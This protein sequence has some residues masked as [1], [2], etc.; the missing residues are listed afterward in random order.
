MQLI[1]SGKL[2][3]PVFNEAAAKL[4]A[5]ST[6]DDMDAG[7]AEQLILA[8]QVLAAEVLRAANSV[9]FGGLSEVNTVR[10]AIVRLGLRQVSELAML[11]S[12]RAEYDA[13]DRS[14]RELIQQLWLH[15]SATA[16]AASWLARKLGYG[17]QTESECFLGGLL[18]DVGKLVIL[19]AVDEIK[20][21]GKAEYD[22]SPQ[23]V[24]EILET[25][26]P[27]LGF[28]FLQ[29]WNVPGLYCEIARDHHLTDFESSKIPLV[30]VRLANNVAAKMGLGLNSDPTMVLS[31]LPEARYLNA[32][33]IL[34][35]EMEIMM[36]DSLSAASN[37]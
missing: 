31:A 37:S 11:A 5:L 17:K 18:H 13:R 1:D 3:L 33:D 16:M 22:L 26:H 4:R 15:A 6:S 35:A 19:R 34:L 12:H 25:T 10:S 29:R 32:S 28:S 9:F 27:G 30:L 24:N 7:Q 2:T 14:L 8:D 23:L 21:A 36:E 20:L